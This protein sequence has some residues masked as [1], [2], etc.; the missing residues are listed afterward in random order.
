M[1]LSASFPTPGIQLGLGFALDA[2]GG[3]VGINRSVEVTELQRLVSDG[4]ADRVLFP[5]NAV[6]RASEIIGS[7]GLV[8]PV[9]TGRMLVGPMVRINLGR[10]D[11]V[12]VRRT[13]PGAARPRARG[14]LG[15]CSSACPTRCCR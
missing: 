6:E 12:A 3:L 14:L 8:F 13:D 7:L 5:G 1:L 9:T 10:A 15:G 4:N 2:I 11:G